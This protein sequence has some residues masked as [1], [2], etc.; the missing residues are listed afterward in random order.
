MSVARIYRVGTPY[1]GAELADLDH[2]QSADT[3]YLAHINHPP[4]KLVRAAHTDWTF[5]TITFAPTLA[6]PGGVG[7]VVTQPNTDAPNSGASFYPTDAHY[8]VTAIDD[9]TGQESRRSAP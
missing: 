3:M 5:S 2:E 8:I 6:V 1:N 4:T 9:D 7:V